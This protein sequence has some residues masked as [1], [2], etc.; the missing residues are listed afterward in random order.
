MKAPRRHEGNEK[1]RSA[2]QIYVDWLAHR[3]SRGQENI[4]TFATQVCDANRIR[5]RMPCMSFAARNRIQQN[6]LWNDL[7]HWTKKQE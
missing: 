4:A 1:K 7:I 5:S 3:A 2:R 6:P